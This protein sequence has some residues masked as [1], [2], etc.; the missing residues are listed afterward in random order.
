MQSTR[1]L[2]QF[3][4]LATTL[5]A[6]FALR[7]NVEA[8][9]PFGGVEAAWTYLRDGDM[10]CSL[11]TSNFFILFG[12]VA[13][14]VLLRRAFCGYLCPIGAISEWIGALGRR[15][16]VRQIRV[17]PGVDRALALLKYGVLLAIVAATWRAGELAF[18]GY[19]PCYALIGRHG[20]DI[21][22]W[23]YA[24]S[25]AI[26]AVSLV[27]SVPFCRWFC[28]LA[29]VLNP[30]SRFA[31]TRI[32]RDDG[33]CNGCA[34]CSRACPEA[35]SVARLDEVKEARCSACFS[36]V[37]ACP[38]AARPLS[39]GPS[40]SFGKGWPRWTLVAT[41]LVCIAG[42]AGVSGLNPVPSFVKQRGQPP[43]ETATVELGVE[44]LT[45]RGKANLLFFFLQR[46]DAAGLVDA[47][48][49]QPAWFRIEAWPGPGASRV[50]VTT[51][52]ACADRTAL[53]RAI[54]EPYYDADNDRWWNPPFQVEG[55]DPLGL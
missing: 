3:A 26:V 41:L 11:A 37:D 7:T 13:S 43:A 46:S 5:W 54:T 34:A 52:A 4:V 48:N 16:G 53:C 9:C 40:R 42:A 24:I 1:R 19:D 18:R 2:L 45:C 35:I 23:A 44:G 33:R 6:V 21:T 47:A 38:V 25:G 29:A 36:C 30:F 15:L 31:L 49:G 10:I 27:A 22:F 50:R 28:P 8:W 39:W 20:E 12:V 32:R 17:R 14:V 51:A 55:Y